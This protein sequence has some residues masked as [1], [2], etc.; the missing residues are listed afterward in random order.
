MVGAV[1]GV[2]LRDP[3]PDRAIRIGFAAFMVVTALRTLAGAAGIL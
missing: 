2:R 3:L 1:V